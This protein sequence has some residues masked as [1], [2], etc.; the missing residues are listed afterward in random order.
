MILKMALLKY[1]KKQLSSQNCSQV[2]PDPTGPLS[3]S[4]PSVAISMVNKEVTKV[5]SGLTLD[6]LAAH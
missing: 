1:L 4:V 2:L 5:T 3:Q 6:K